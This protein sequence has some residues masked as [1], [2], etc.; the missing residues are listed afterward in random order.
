MSTWIDLICPSLSRRTT[1]SSINALGI[2]YRYLYDGF[3]APT[4]TQVLQTVD[5]LSDLFDD[6]FPINEYDDKKGY[7]GILF[8]RYDGM[9]SLQ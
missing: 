5:V 6:A 2:E 1:T 7:R 8:G 3:Y 9:N 4:D